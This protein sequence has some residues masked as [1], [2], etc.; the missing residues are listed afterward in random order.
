[1]SVANANLPARDA[2]LLVEDELGVRT[3]VGLYL[4]RASLKVLSCGSPAEA[5]EYWK[6]HRDR[7][8]LVL[9][10]YNLMAEQTGKDLIECFR[11][12]CATLPAVLMSGYV[13]NLDMSDWLV[14][15]QV[16]F[17]P[18]PFS[19]ADFYRVLQQAESGPPSPS[20]LSQAWDA[21]VHQCEQM[22]SL[23]PRLSPGC[24]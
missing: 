20:A 1:M 17:L 21:F 11:Q 2:V 6:T 8:K 5:R 13:S 16:L 12:D 9:T 18:K 3:L 4:S 22:E 7:I 19:Y 23:V 15:N 10:D 24:S 14:E